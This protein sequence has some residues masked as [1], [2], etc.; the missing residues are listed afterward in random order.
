MPKWE[1]RIKVRTWGFNLGPAC[2]IGSLAYFS[3][4]TSWDLYQFDY[5]NKKWSELPSCPTTGYALVVVNNLLT[6]VG[7]RQNYNKLFSLCTT[8]GNWVERFPPMQHR[9]VCPAHRRRTRGV[10][11]AMTPPPPPPPPT[12]LHSG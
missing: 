6:T 7:G 11:G 3:P 1:E 12:F 10:R 9:H 2:S 4:Q 8:E 5:H